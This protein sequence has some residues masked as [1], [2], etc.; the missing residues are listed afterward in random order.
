MRKEFADS[1][2]QL[3]AS[4]S[5]IVFITG[6]LG[7]KALEN[8]Q[9]ALGNRFINAG[10]AEQN[11]VSM[12]AGM[13]YKGFKVVCYSIAPFIVYRCLEQTR[14]DVC[15][16]RLPV[17]LV[18]NGGGYGYGIM[19]SSHHAIE[20]LA[21]LSTLPNMN[22]YIPS[23]VEDLETSIQHIFTESKPAYLRLGLGKNKSAWLQAMP[24][25]YGYIPSTGRLT[26]LVQGPVANNLLAAIDATK[27]EQ[28][29]IFIVNKL[30]LTVL[31]SEITDS[32]KQTQKLLIIEEHV[33]I[34]GLGSAVNQLIL[35][36]G[37]A[38]TKYKLLCA[39]G[40]P[41][42]RFGSQDFHQQESG[43]DR[44]SIKKQIELLLYS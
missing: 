32:L 17:F 30:P 41:S 18:G 7:Y 37:I 3:G 34:G 4:D 38:L 1:I 20:D 12:A 10:V 35:N 15:F 22:C 21:C 39:A 6:D 26:V 27:Q 2:A 36:E 14:N 8:V 42:H 25:G 5:N 13:A 28:L 43:L 23:F 44:D 24:Y 40:Y 19:G 31:P 29:H 16:H 9:D 33:G 11:M